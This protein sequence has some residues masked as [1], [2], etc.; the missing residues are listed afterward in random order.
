MILLRQAEHRANDRKRQIA[1][2]LGHEIDLRSFLHLV[3]KP[4][5]YL[6]DHRLHGLDRLALKR[7]VNEAAQAAVLR[8]VMAEHILRQK[9]DGPRQESEYPRLCSAPCVGRVASEAR[10]I[11]QQRCAGVMC[12]GE[13]CAADNRQLHANDW[14]L[15]A[16]P[17][18]RGEGVCVK[19]RR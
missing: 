17:V 8:V 12:H 2:E 7:L 9:A 19:V 3:E 6:R 5:G 15:G 1:T 10:V 11:L 14:P 4:I 16:H 13:P 18:S